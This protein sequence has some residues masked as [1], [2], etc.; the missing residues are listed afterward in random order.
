MTK[1]FLNM[2]ED[3]YADLKERAQGMLHYY[4]LEG[5]ANLIDRHEDTIDRY[6]DMINTLEL[7]VRR[8][9]EEFEKVQFA[10]GDVAEIGDEITAR[11]DKFWEKENE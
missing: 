2:D 6:A 11:I 7:E 4:G 5:M 1:H 8:M 9:Q 10:Y 3:E